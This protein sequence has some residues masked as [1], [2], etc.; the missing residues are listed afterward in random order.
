MTEQ[1]HRFK[2]PESLEQH[3]AAEAKRLREEAKGT[4]PGAVRDALLRKA[5]QA[6]TASQMEGWLRSSGL[7]PPK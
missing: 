3:L 4:L 7:Q 6:E 5:R 2:Q 1:R